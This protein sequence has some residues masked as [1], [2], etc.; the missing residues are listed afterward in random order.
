MY[1]K[2]MKFM[3]AYIQGK[4]T[5]PEGGFAVEYKLKGVDLIITLKLED[6]INQPDG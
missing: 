2:L 6:D 5:I 4:M 3:V 1:D